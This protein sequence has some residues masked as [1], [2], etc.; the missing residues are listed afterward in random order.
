MR[1]VSRADE[2]YDVNFRIALKDDVVETVVKTAG[3]WPNQRDYDVHKE[4]LNELLQH[5]IDG[6]KWHTKQGDHRAAQKH[7][8]VVGAITGTLAAIDQL[9]K[10]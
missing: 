2:S 7:A 4:H 10:Q 9:E 8:A 6:V 1:K 3:V 5:N